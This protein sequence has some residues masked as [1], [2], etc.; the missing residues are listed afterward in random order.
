MKVQWLNFTVHPNA[1]ALL[2][3]FYQDSSEI[4][5]SRAGRYAGIYLPYLHLMDMSWI[6]F[7]NISQEILYVLHLSQFTLCSL[8]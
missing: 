4:L 5:V 3:L 6:L 7:P 1:P 2:L 8:G